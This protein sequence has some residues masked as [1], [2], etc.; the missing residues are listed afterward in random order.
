MS[1][2][3][4]TLHIP[5]FQPSFPFPWPQNSFDEF[6]AVVFRKHKAMTAANAD[7]DDD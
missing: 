4:L 6:F 1:S 3:S 2:L 7:N 5:I